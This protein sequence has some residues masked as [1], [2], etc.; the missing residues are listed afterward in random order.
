[1]NFIHGELKKIWLKEETKPKQRYRNRDIKEGDK[2][3]AYF[4]AVANQRRKTLI[5]SLDGP[6]TE[7]KDMIG[8]ASDFYKNIFKKEESSGFSLSPD[9]FSLM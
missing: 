7:I 3:N 8:I 1:M 2:N 6:A 4:H 9:F 5:H